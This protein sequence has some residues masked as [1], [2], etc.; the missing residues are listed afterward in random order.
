MPD[1]T[2]LQPQSTCHLFTCGCDCGTPHTAVPD[3]PTVRFTKPW[4][5][6]ADRGS[7]MA[8]CHTGL[9]YVRWTGGGHWVEVE[10]L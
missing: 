5:A 4:S 1:A 2:R 6:G 7:A 3:G 8:E 10:S 9:T